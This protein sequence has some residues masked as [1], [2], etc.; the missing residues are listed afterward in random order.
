MELFQKVELPQISTAS[1]YEF[2]TF[3]CFTKDICLGI[4]T[5]YFS[6]FVQKLKVP[7]Y[8]IFE[9]NMYQENVL[10]NLFKS[11]V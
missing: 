5:K 2:I 11:P 6:D 10:E 1:Q 3:K 4:P 8:T 7:S 9:H